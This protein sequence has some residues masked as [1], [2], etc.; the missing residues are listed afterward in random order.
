MLAASAAAASGQSASGSAAS[1]K[2]PTAGPTTKPTSQDMED[3]AMYRP[4]S[5]AGARS[6]TSAACVGPW[7]QLARPNPTAASTKTT[8]AAVPFAKEPP[9]RTTS[10]QTV[11]AAGITASIFSRRLPSTNRAT[12]S[13]ATTSAIVL[14][15]KITP[16]Q[17][18]ETPLWFFANTGSSSKTA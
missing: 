10:Q 12:G 11:N 16:I 17:R 2:P 8:A 15:K 5:L 3:S 14:K 1:T 18:S 13:C 6:A 4:R 9:A 7:K